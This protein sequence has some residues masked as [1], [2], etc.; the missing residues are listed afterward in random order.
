[1]NVLAQFNEAVLYI[2][3]LRPFGHYGEAGTIVSLIK[4]LV[5]NTGNFSQFR[6]KKKDLTFEARLE[7]RPL[8]QKPVSLN[9]KSYTNL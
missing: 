8:F 7:N 1:V 9:S 2:A 6:A 4:D 5:E 3:L